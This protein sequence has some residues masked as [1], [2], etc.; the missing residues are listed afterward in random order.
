MTPGPGE[1]SHGKCFREVLYYHDIHGI[2]HIQ[3]AATGRDFRGDY[4]IWIRGEPDYSHLLGVWWRRIY[5]GWIDPFWRQTPWFYGGYGE[6]PGAPITVAEL[7]RKILRQWD[8]E[9]F[10]PII[11]GGN[12]VVGYSSYRRVGSMIEF[13][14]EYEVAAPA[15]QP[16]TQEDLEEPED[17]DND[18]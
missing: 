6:G 17:Y 1:V 8:I 13:S 4:W 5:E 9:L 3:V 18:D 11:E 7:V 12:R 10:D 15:G 16:I 2:P 14:C